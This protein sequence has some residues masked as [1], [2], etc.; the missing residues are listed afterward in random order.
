VTNTELSEKKCVP[1]EG[2]VAALTREEAEML[3]AKLSPGWQLSDDTKLIRREFPFKNFYRTMSFV[4]AIAHIANIEDHH[5]DLEV[6]YSYCRVVFSTHA[7]KGLSENDF[8]C[9][10][11]IDRIPLA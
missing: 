7:I 4:N 9:A 2:G 6:G 10:A 1:C 8:I 3:R 11:K 5:P